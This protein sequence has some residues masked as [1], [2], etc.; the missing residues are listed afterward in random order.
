VEFPRGL[1]L[2]ARPY[3]PRLTSDQHIIHADISLLTDI[4]KGAASGTEAYVGGFQI[5]NVATGEWSWLVEASFEAPFFG[6]SVSS[7]GDVFSFVTSTQRVIVARRVQRDR[8]EAGA[9][10]VSL[11]NASTAS[12]LVPLVHTYDPLPR[13]VVQA[14][15]VDGERDL[16]VSA[17]WSELAL[18]RIDGDRLDVLD[19]GKTHTS[20]DVKWIAIAGEHVAYAVHDLMQGTRI[21]VRQL[22][23]NRAFGTHVEAMPIRRGFQ[24]AAL[25][26]DGRFL[27]TAFGKVLT[28]YEL[29]TSRIV[30]FKEHTDEIN[31]VRFAA[32]DHV[33]ISADT[34]HRVVLRPRTPRGYD[35]PLMPVD[36]T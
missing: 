31:Y 18:H 3:P 5:T 23:V 11:T 25:S 4:A 14:L 20:G 34:D 35:V 24:C 19:R 29:G 16:M 12:Q 8:T 28:V 33:L 17:S 10:A 7:I 9:S 30:D 27:A 6:T 13:K 15:H 36:L 1:F 26:R 21:E 22:T 2:W 32:D